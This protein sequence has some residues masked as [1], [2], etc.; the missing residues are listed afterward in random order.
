[1][2][3]TSLIFS[4]ITGVKFAV[5]S[6]VLFLQAQVGELGPMG[7][8]YQNTVHWQP[9]PTNYAKDVSTFEQNKN[10]FGMDKYWLEE[11]F[12][13]GLQFIKNQETLRL[14]IFGKTIDCQSYAFGLMKK[15]VNNR[16]KSTHATTELKLDSMTEGLA[17]GINYPDFKIIK[18][19]ELV[20]GQKIVGKTFLK[21]FDTNEA[22]FD[23]K[24]PIAGIG[25]YLYTNS[26]GRIGYIRPYLVAMNYKSFF[27]IKC[28]I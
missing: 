9:L 24:S 14:R 22:I 18:D 17:T 6:G 2:S 1:L 11:N 5:V 23:V 7:T 12:L 16:Y 10:F 19:K 28:A 3:L 20:F 26:N 27:T 13:T 15:N 25:F 4:V 21:F 8:V